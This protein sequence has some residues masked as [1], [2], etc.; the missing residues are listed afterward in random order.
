MPRQWK[1]SGKTWRCSR[2]V[3]DMSLL[4][5]V[6]A[7]EIA[8]QA[9]MDGYAEFVNCGLEKPEI[10][11]LLGPGLDRVGTATALRLQKVQAFIFNRVIGLGLGRP[12]T[13]AELD[14]LIEVYRQAG[15]TRYGFQLT[16]WAQP[17]ELPSWLE[18]RGFRAGDNWAKC[19]RGAAP[20]PQISTGLAIK[21]V[22][23][24]EAL[25]F[26]EIACKVFHLPAILQPWTALTV[27]RAG[28]T[29]YMAYD[30]SKPVATGALLVRGELGWLGIG[31][32]LPEFRR[33]GAQGALMAR[34]IQAG[35][36][37]GCR[38]LVTET[39]EDSQA[40]PNPS[41]H[42]MMRSGFKLA[43]LRRNYLSPACN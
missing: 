11:T 12:A 28:W 10:A 23:P 16:P 27:G 42:N 18:K 21:T 43:Y 3:T 30:G 13:E 20:A 39:P 14:R 41:F 6:S 1:L 2:E 17:A 5:Q 22:G 31:A 32:T 19:L 34:R 33:R 35:R 38:W 40:R 26:A 7:A 24:D 37:Q 9:E 36:A 25:S 8:E 29:H 4:E 15:I